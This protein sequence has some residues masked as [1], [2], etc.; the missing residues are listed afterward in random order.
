MKK[1]LRLPAWGAVLVLIAGTL[2]FTAAALLIQPG[3]T[4]VLLQH[5]AEQPLLLLLNCLPALLLALLLWFLCGNPFYAAA[6]AGLIVDILSYVNLVKTGC[7]N[8]PL[9]PAD[10]GLLREALTA[11]REYALDLHPKAL[12]GLLLLAAAVGSL[13]VFFRCPK[14]RRV[15]RLS[16][17]AAILLA[18]FWAMSGLYTNHSLFMRLAPDVDKANVPL[19]YESCGF[20]YCFLANYGRYTIQKP[21][22]YF[23]EE[24]ERLQ[25]S[26]K[27]PELSAQVQPNVLF[28][29]CEAYSDLSE[30]AVFSWKQ[31]DDPFYG[32]RQ[33]ADS[34]RA[35]SGHLVV[36][37]FGAGTANT[38]FDV[39]TGIATEQLGVNSAFRAVRRNLNSL[40]RAFSRAG[41]STYFL[42]P[43]YRWYYNRES[44][45]GYLGIEDC[46]F[47]DA[48]SESDYKGP[49]VSDAAFLDRL[50][51]D[52]DARLVGNTP[53]FAFGVTIQNHQ[54]YT[55]AKYGEVPPL[56]VSAEL[57]AEETEA[58]S[59]YLQGV[60]DSSAMLL[61]LTEY[62]DSL[63]E[64]FLLVFW[65]D[66]RPAL[67]KDFGAYRA[68]GL[69]MDG[70]EAYKTPYLLWANRAY[71]T[72]CNFSVLDLPETMN[73]N[74]LGAAVYELAG[75][76]GLDPYF[77]ELEDIRR[78]IP[79]AAHDVCLAGDG[80]LLTP[81]Q[82]RLIERL[83]QWAYY[84]I[85][86]EILIK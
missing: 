79:V 18:G 52:L 73:A 72:S 34:G 6:G 49:T 13:G 78:T 44:V 67:L 55:Y 64:S 22:D 51:A 36:N 15:F 81:A 35:V 19:T 16:G 26:D 59:V 80:S 61:R 7:R 84:R 50:I 42:H 21:A 65:G 62:L 77:D 32:F 37:N 69:S 47:A 48:F 56:S 74:Y 40:P 60:R 43:G 24:F 63:E 23:P 17:A 41:Y 4:V 33:V 45:Y 20:P 75:L 83:S 46:V 38:E 12:A 85:K 30:E 14:L 70:L 53:I 5:F 11:T 68:L 57:T 2:L 10:L 54:S 27:M 82:N 76:S 1:K 9:V 66:H 58:L 29:M 39:M 8:D 3:R 71:A 25:Q 28:V 31:E 86:D